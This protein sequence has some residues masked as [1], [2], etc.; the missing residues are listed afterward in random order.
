MLD[1]PPDED[2]EDNAQ[3]EVDQNGLPTD[4]A[5]QEE[6]EEYEFEDVMEEILCEIDLHILN[7][8]KN[9]FQVHD[10]EDNGTLED[11]QHTNLGDILDVE[12][13][14]NPLGGVR[15]MYAGFDVCLIINWT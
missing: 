14:Q 9:L 15:N 12:D 2:E 5:A 11:D 1:H 7:N 4:G 8:L 3:Q 6:E 10:M 13:L